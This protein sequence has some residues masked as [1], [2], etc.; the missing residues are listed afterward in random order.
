VRLPRPVT[1]ICPAPSLDHRFPDATPIRTGLLAFYDGGAHFIGSHLDPGTPGLPDCPLAVEGDLGV[2]R[3]AAIVWPSD[4]ERGEVVAL[5]SGGEVPP[6]APRTEG[7]ESP[8]WVT[9]ARIQLAWLRGET[10]VIADP[11]PPTG[12]SPWMVRGGTFAGEQ[13]L[14]VG[15]YT[16][17]ASDQV[18]RR[19]PWIYRV[20]EGDDALPRLAPRWRGHSFAH[21]FRDATFGDFT[22]EG[23]GE[24]AALEVREDGGRQL[25]A[26]RFEDFG[27]EGLAA[28]VE[29]PPVEDRLAVADWVAGGADELII[30]DVEG[31]FHFY[32]LG[33]EY[34]ELRE[35]LTITGPRAVLGWAITSA[36]TAHPGRLVCVLPDGD[37]WRTDSREQTAS[38]SG[39]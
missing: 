17:A 28:S 10:L 24:I 15:V 22:G 23:E 32:E 29:L 2:V 4:S 34:G 9:S 26:Y 20:V 21:P 19:R 16:Q 27:L 6:R 36:S 25:T 31:R 1:A 38:G 37:V 3:D 11:A 18:V 14:L 30:R 12:S 7:A 39:D 5:I 33:A 35:V 8:P 13:N